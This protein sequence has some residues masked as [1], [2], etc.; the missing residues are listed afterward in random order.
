MPPLDLSFF[1]IAGPAVVF[2]GISKG[3]FGSGAAFASAAILA[4]VMEPGAAIGVMLPLLMLIDLATLKPY[5]KRW[6]THDALVLILGSLPGVVLGAAFYTVAD[7]DHL[8][9][10]IGGIALLF[11]AWQIAGRAGKI[12]VAGRPIPFWGGLVAGLAAGFT[13]FVAHAGGPAA[14]VYLLSKRPGKTEFQATTVIVFWANNVLK[15]APYGFLGIFTAETLWA[16]LWLAPFALFGTWLGVR[17]HF[18]IPERVFFA[19]TYV[20]L[21]VTGAKLVWDGLS[22]GS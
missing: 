17:A 11:V 16:G 9:L 2:A 1:A 18:A 8:R 20:L 12:P 13:S 14:A 22:Q 7:A 4:L 6:N 3:G 5:W 19:L 10:L 21:T 15:A